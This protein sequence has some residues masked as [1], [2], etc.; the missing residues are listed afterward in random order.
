MSEHLEI[1]RRRECVAAP[2]IR[3][4]ISLPMHS[5]R[6]TALLIVLC[7]LF[8]PGLR[9]QDEG[10]SMEGALFLLL[11]TSAKAVGLARAMTALSGAESVWWN[12]AGLA[13]VQG[14][15]LLLYRG[16]HPVAG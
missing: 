8:A 14:S 11:P 13:M 2:R 16:D 6:T 9:A 12:P 10:P 3:Q 5:R 4:P 1:V 7:A 15:R